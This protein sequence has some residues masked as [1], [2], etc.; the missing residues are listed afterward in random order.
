MLSRNNSGLPAVRALDDAARA[1]A[2]S[3]LVR[4]YHR[5]AIECVAL[6]IFSALIA[7]WLRLP[8]MRDLWTTEYGL[9]LLRKIVVVVIVL[10]F[11]LFHWR[12]AVVREW[13]A[14]TAKRFRI[15]AT[16]EVLAGGVVI[17]LTAALISTAL[18]HIR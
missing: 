2:G 5:T 8:A 14:T 10:G 9:A 12:T 15:S 7:A 13:S 3:S 6:T 18:P 4:T 17:A 16:L 11:G 1:A